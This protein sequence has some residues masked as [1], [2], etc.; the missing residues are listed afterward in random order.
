M[1]STKAFI[2]G[3]GAAYVLSK[4]ARG[5][6][7]R[8]ATH[9]LRLVNQADVVADDAA[10]EQQIRNDVLPET[11]ISPREVEIE[12]EAGVVALR[13]S[14][15]SSKQADELL[16]RIASVPCVRDVAAMLRVKAA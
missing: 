8:A 1:R 12:V 7:Q 4:I 6:A 14:V 13:G 9:S 2:I 3:A 5:G 15:R 16:G 10:I 11:G